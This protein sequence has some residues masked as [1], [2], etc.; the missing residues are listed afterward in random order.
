MN[1][2]TRRLFRLRVFCGL[3]FSA[4]LT[5]PAVAQTATLS[6][7]E[8]LDLARRNNPDYLARAND[9]TSADWAVREAYGAL[10]PGASASSSLSWQGAGTQRI[11]IFTGEDF[12]LGSTT[13]YYSSSYSLSL[14]YR[15]TG[16]ALL[17]PG[18]E[19]ANRR[20]T[21]AGIAF[22]RSSLETT[23]VQQYLA[24]R[25]AQD[26]VILAREELDRTDENLRLARARAAVGAVAE[27]EAAQAEVERGRAEVALVQAE[28]DAETQRFA[29]IQLVG[30]DLDSD[31]MLTTTF[32]VME[33]P[34]TLE[35]LIA[36]AR[37]SN[38]ELSSARATENASDVSVRMARTAYLPSLSISTGLTG[39]TRE[40]GNV[41]Y[42]IDQA[43]NQVQGA[44]EQ[45][46]YENM[47]SARLVQ[48]L[49]GRP[50]DCSTFVLTPQ[51]EAQIRAGNSVFPFSFEREPLGVSLTLSLPIFE[52][53]ARER[54]VEEAKV[55]A[56]DASLRVRSTELRVRRA[57]ATAY[58]AL[59]TARR[60]VELE[61]RNR[62]LADRQLALA[63]E[64]YRLGSGT[65]IEL[66]EAE[67]AKARADRSH[68]S[69]LYQFH[70]GLASLEGVLGRS[71][72]PTP[73]GR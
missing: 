46:E 45:C 26:G 71:L 20:A 1:T 66:K 4:L 36:Q 11:G 39:Y 64:R 43:R 19:K 60:S 15:L 27:L 21:E 44:R 51:R 8:A 55:A 16:A 62:A 73:E 10:L 52:G 29:L 32:E 28:G 31:L 54:Q 34:W 24:L 53:F 12:G 41:Q 37:E 61:E 38:P 58:S 70:E 35:E 6:L 14:N 63:R 42:L 50:A 68:L 7:T 72:R 17:A 2:N 9:A 56:E 22:E 23:V 40:A 59:R 13:S 25:R 49:P 33:L 3:V 57:V 18:R 47:L 30:I 48:P 65:F 5:Q 69:A 67:T